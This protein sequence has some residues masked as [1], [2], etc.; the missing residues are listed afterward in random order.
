M[1]GKSGD[2]TLEP[3]AAG[4]KM[5]CSCVSVSRTTGVSGSTGVNGS[6]GAKGLAAYLLPG[7]PPRW[8]RAAPVLVLG[9]S[10]SV[11]PVW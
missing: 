11:P 5:G 8:A 4:R 1:G 3:L 2:G 6:M 9:A 10:C 7:A